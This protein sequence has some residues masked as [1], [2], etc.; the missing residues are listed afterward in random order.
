[1]RSNIA[2]KRVLFC[3]PFSFESGVHYGSIK[4]TMMNTDASVSVTAYNK[5]RDT[6]AHKECLQHRSNADELSRR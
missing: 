1:V 6:E 3:I 5:R 2:D 4:G